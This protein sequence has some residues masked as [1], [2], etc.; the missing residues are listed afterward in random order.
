MPSTELTGGAG[1]RSEGVG[2]LPGPVTEGGVAKLPDERNASWQ[3]PT[4]A[5]AAATA[6]AAAAGAVEAAK[7][8]STAI[9][10][11]KI[12]AVYRR[13]TDD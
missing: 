9:G 5:G 12:L 2:A 3:I 1:E 7:Q 4:T 6:T 11:Y 13:P 8:K 10:D